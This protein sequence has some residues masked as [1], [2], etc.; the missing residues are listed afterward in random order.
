MSQRRS[1]ASS[2]SSDDSTSSL[3]AAV[4]ASSSS[5][6]PAPPHASSK[7]YDDDDDEGSFASSSDTDTATALAADREAYEDE[8][9]QR[10]ARQV[11]RL[12]RSSGREKEGKP[13]RVMHSLG[14]NKTTMHKLLVRRPSP[15]GRAAAQLSISTTVHADS[16]A[17]RTSPIAPAQ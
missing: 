12:A 17:A 1:A 7:S 8:R 15:F 10:K 4:R 3:D 16:N 2:D 9:S 13:V 5:R 6:R 14:L 11:A